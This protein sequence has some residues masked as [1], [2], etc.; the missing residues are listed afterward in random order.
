MRLSHHVAFLHTAAHELSQWQKTVERLKQQ[1]PAIA[2]LAP[3]IFNELAAKPE[4]ERRP[5]PRVVR[6]PPPL[7]NNP[8]R[9]KPRPLPAPRWLDSG[10]GFSRWTIVF[11]ITL[12]IQFLRMFSSGI[13]TPSNWSNSAPPRQVEVL[14]EPPLGAEKTNVDATLK[15]LYGVGD[16]DAYRYRGRLIFVKKKPPGNAPADERPGSSP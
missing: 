12:A 6:A 14:S 7:I 11:L 9:P 13:M 10:S 15:E 16:V 1:Q 3:E 8:R 4:P 2:R 5:R